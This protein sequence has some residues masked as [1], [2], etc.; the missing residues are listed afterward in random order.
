MA[1]HGK[2]WR[3]LL[4]KLSLNPVD[5]IENN[6]EAIMDALSSNHNISIIS[7]Y[8]LEGSAWNISQQS[9]THLA[10]KNLL[11]IHPDKIQPLIMKYTLAT[12]MSSDVMNATKEDCEIMVTK[13]NQLYHPGLKK[14]YVMFIKFNLYMCVCGTSEL[15]K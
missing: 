2:L 6:S 4:K 8:S 3:V 1:V 11:S 14:Q 9:A 15:C 5:V 10:L 12:F 7:K 13:P